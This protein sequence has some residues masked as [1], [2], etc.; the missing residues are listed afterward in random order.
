MVGGKSTSLPFASRPL[1]PESLRSVA[2]RDTPISISE[3]VVKGTGSM[4]G[5][6]PEVTARDGM[7]RLM[8]SRGSHTG[9]LRFTRVRGE[10]GRAAVA[11]LG[12]GPRI[13][14]A[15]SNR[16]ISN[17]S[18]FTQKGASEMRRLVLKCENQADGPSNGE[19]NPMA[20]ADRCHYR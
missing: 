11:G 20:S 4:S 9:G 1:L 14:D 7:V 8:R 15:C 6:Q 18:H 10:L 12:D 2:H 3:L 13:C 16:S 17:K 5:D 19:K